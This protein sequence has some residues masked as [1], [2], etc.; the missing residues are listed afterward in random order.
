MRAAEIDASDDRTGL[1]E[2]LRRRN[3]VIGWLRLG[4]P[5]F[6]AI[7]LAVLAVQIVIANLARE[8]GI[9]GIRLSHDEVVIDTPAYSGVMA[10][11]TQ[12]TVKAEQASTA[13]GDVETIALT[14]AVVDLVRPDGSSM[15]ARAASADFSLVTQI[16][17]V[18]GEMLVSDSRGME[19]RL[20]NSA[21]NWPAQTFTA[22]DRVEIAFS[23]GSTLKASSLRYDAGAQSWDFRFVALT[24]PSGESGQ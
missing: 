7:V 24:I 12:Y 19:A 18:D 14:N 17:D 21:I 1:Y 8:F 22:R 6:G 11:G 4:V 13:I 10:N 2:A 15:R 3:S 16:V 20:L 5:A 9:S 23:D